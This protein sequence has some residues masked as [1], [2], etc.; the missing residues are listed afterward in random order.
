[1]G[2]HDE[3][4]DG[5]GF[6]GLA[7]SPQE[8]AAETYEQTHNKV[9]AAREATIKKQAAEIGRLCADN[10]DLEL[11]R[12]RLR[13]ERDELSEANAGLAFLSADNL[14]LRAEVERLTEDRARFPDK[15]DDIGRMIEAH[16]GNLKAGKESADA[17]ARNAYTKLAE[18]RRQTIEECAAIAD[19]AVNDLNGQ[20]KAG[21]ARAIARCIRALGDEQSGGS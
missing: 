16:I 2:R 9:A 19:S 12:N 13:A 18:V 1:M 6:S 15:P 20:R 14:R 10:V 8:R 4:E 3:V 5:M 17:H 7:P 21:M 11:D